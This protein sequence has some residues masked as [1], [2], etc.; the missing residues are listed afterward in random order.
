[1][2]INFHSAS[3]VLVCLGKTKTACVHGVS[4][5]PRP[6]VVLPLF[7]SALFTIAHLS[8]SRP[9]SNPHSW[10]VV[11][12]M[13]P[14]AMFEGSLAQPSLN[15]WNQSQ[16]QLAPGE[17]GGFGNIPRGSGRKYWWVYCCDVNVC[18]CVCMF[19]YIC[20]RKWMCVHVWPANGGRSHIMSFRLFSIF[21]TVIM[22]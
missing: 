11:V 13:T 15:K 17:G 9:S 8:L 18:M 14:S 22:M 1:M 10:D 21:A 16:K 3:S 4:S 12:S 5:F 19:T 7:Q 6:S 2:V 20:V